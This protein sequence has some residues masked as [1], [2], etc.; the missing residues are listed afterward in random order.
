MN[1]HYNLIDARTGAPLGDGIIVSMTPPLNIATGTV[2]LLET[3]DGEKAWQ[4]KHVIVPLRRPGIYN[5]FRQEEPT[6]VYVEPFA[7]PVF[8]KV[9]SDW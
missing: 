4:I 1:V 6:R 3:N 9:R 5:S 8:D 7:M 2:F